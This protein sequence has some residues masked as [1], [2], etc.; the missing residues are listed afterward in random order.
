[1]SGLNT[2]TIK[3]AKGDN[4][5]AIAKKYGVKSDR[6]WKYPENKKVAQTRGR[7]EKLQPGDPLVIPPSDKELQA[8]QKDLENNSKVVKGEMDRIKRRVAALDRAAKDIASSV[9]DAKKELQGQAS[10]IENVSNAADLA[11]VVIGL[12]KVVSGTMK[13][14]LAAI[15]KTGVELEKHNHEVQKESIN[16]IYSPFK[17]VT[18][19]VVGNSAMASDEAVILIQEVAKAY[20]KMTSPSFWT[21]TIYQLGAGKSW[22]EAVNTKVSKE[23]QDRSDELEAV[24][25]SQLNKLRR[26]RAGILA[27]QHQLE[28]AEKQLQTIAK[29]LQ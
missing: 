26:M 17:A 18:V 29:G 11:S 21:N 28:A 23:L 15:E 4:I 25:L 8:A 6:I 20:D 16:L 22:S 5:E 27:H 3:F 9:D 1:M 7:P 10:K 13:K 24:K 2:H 12:G 19:K 14:G